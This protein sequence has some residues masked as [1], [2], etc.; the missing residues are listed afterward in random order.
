MA[1]RTQ[2]KPIQIDAHVPDARHSKT[3][4]YTTTAR[5][6]NTTASDVIIATPPVDQPFRRSRSLVDA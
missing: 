2:R 5:E 3:G 6:M 4:R 1:A